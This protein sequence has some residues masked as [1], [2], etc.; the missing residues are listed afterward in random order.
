MPLC[1]GICVDVLTRYTTARPTLSLV[2]ERGHR[3]TVDEF[4]RKDPMPHSGAGLVNGRGGL[5]GFVHGGG[6]FVNGRGGLGGFVHGG[7][8]FVNGRGGL[9][10]FVHGGGLVNGRVATW[11][12]TAA[13]RDALLQVKARAA[14]Q[15]VRQA[16][17]EAREARFGDPKAMLI[18]RCRQDCADYR[19]ALLA[20]M[21][22]EVREEEASGGSDEP[23]RD[24]PSADEP[25]VRVL[26]AFSG[27]TY[28][29]PL[30]PRMTS[31][32]LG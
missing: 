23:S 12:R 20:L 17:A 30:M 27:E 9:G 4:L 7:G 6:G 22:Q 18:V 24:E 32:D 3:Q 21:A 26:V 16:F 19:A 10:G 25:P 11:R 28:P 5:G 2:D 29:S 14:L 31:D 13:A 15:F 1:P 8:G